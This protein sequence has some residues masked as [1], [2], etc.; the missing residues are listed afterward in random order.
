LERWRELDANLKL[1]RAVERACHQW[2]RLAT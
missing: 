1:R 2:E